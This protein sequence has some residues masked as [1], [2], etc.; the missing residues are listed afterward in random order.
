TIVFAGREGAQASQYTIRTN[1]RRLDATFTPEAD[2]NYLLV[3]IASMAAKYLRE[4]CMQLF[5]SFWTTRIPGLEPTAGY[6]GDASRFWKEIRPVC[7]RLGF[8]HD[9]LWRQ[10]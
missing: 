6:P 9:T 10:R 2:N 7:D 5:N 3:A 1:S 4:L 8:A